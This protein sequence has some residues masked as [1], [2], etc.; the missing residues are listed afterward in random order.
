VDIFWDQKIWKKIGLK[1]VFMTV[2]TLMIASVFCSFPFYLS[3]YNALGGGTENGYKIA[4]DSNYDWGGSD[5]RRLAE[6]MRSNNVRVIYTDFFADVALPY[7][8]G[9][10]QRNFNIEDGVLPPPGSLIAVS[11]YKYMNNVFNAKFSANQKYS[12]LKK[13][14][15]ARIGPTIMVFKVPEK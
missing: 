12:I 5:V 11:N 10:G 7:Y 14:L 2:G 8:L 1:H 13:N 15:I 6:W 9:D 3:Y 4:T